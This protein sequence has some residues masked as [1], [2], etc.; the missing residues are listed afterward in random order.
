MK[1]STPLA[2]WSFWAWY[3]GHGEDHTA[4]MPQATGEQPRLPTLRN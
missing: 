4:T 3:M 2:L 1:N